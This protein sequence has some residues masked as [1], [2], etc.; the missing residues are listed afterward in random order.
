MR[1]G[2]ICYQYPGP[3]ISVQ[4]YSYTKQQQI[5]RIEA[6]EPVYKIFG[7]PRSAQ[8]ELLIIDANNKKAAQSIKKCHDVY[9]DVFVGPQRKV[10]KKHYG[11]SDGPYSGQSRIFLATE[12][13][14]GK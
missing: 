1:K 8:L 11:R 14:F 6:C 4:K 12:L 13:Y 10:I 2:K 7:Q 3:K 9:R 5:H